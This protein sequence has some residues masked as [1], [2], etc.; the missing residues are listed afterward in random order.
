VTLGRICAVRKQ[1]LDEI[2]RR[3]PTGFHRWISSG[4]WVRGDSAP[5]LG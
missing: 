5:F 1:Q 4:Y 3:D 2:E